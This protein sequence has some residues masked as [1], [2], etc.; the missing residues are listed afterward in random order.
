M[1]LNSYLRIWGPWDPPGFSV[2]PVM[3]CDTSMTLEP[4]ETIA[5]CDFIELPPPT[6]L[7]HVQACLNEWPRYLPRFNP[8]GLP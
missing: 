6:L 4:G 8:W 3:R 2:G 5:V 1:R 7:D